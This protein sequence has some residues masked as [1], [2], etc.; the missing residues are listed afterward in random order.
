MDEVVGVGSSSN[1]NFWL[2]SFIEALE[3]RERDVLPVA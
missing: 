1:D 2:I 3:S